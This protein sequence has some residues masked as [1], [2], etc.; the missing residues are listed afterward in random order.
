MKNN[1]TSI[2]PEKV[3]NQIA[4]LSNDSIHGSTFLTKKAI[5]IVKSYINEKDLS[6]INFETLK[7]M[8]SF[9]VDAQPTMALLFSFSNK[10]LFFLDE[11]NEENKPIAEN[12][13]SII[14]FLEHFS[15]SLKKGKSLISQNAIHHL[16][17]TSV[18]A[19]Y[20]SSGTIQYT[21]EKLSEQNTSITVYCA[22]SRPKYEGTLLAQSLAKKGIDVNLMTDA[23][24][25]SKIKDVNSLVIGADAITKQGNINKI[26]SYPLAQLASDYTIPIYCLAH[27]LKII[28]NEYS[29]QNESKKPDTD[30]LSE[31]QEN[32]AVINYYFDTTPLNLFNGII[33]EKGFFQPVDIKEFIQKQ[34]LHPFLRRND[35]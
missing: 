2:L 17:S 9:I 32:I 15:Q 30:L 20:S 21:I 31:K 10:F 34:S 22:E 1:D 24:L 18:I 11:L 16:L 27:S 7:N 8:L 14:T 23:T 19:T 33:T 12:K 5:N 35:S 26:G 25:F 3:S 6:E 28:P 4:A 13:E 29:L